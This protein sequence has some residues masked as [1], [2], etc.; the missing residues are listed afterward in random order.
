MINPLLLVVVGLVIGLCVGLTGVGGGALMTPILVLLGID[1]LTAVSSDLVVS[2]VMKPIGSSVHMRRGTVDRKIVVWLA[3]GSVPTAFLGAI[4]LEMFG[5]GTA[6]KQTVKYLLGAALLLAL[7]GML[8]RQEIAGRRLKHDHVESNEL[9]DAQQQQ[10]Q[11]AE[12]DGSLKLSVTNSRRGATIALGAVGGLIV[13]LTSV[14]SG[15][16][17]IVGLMWLFPRL[18][19]RS[20]VGTDL[21]QAIPLVGSAAIGHAL[22][23]RVDFGLALPLLIGAVPAVYLGARLSSKGQFSVIL[24]PILMVLIGLSALQLVGVPPIRS[25]AIVCVVTVFVGGAFWRRDRKQLGG[26]GREAFFDEPDS[27][28]TLAS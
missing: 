16:L 14:G 21:V 18:E 10:S 12:I 28:R 15:S 17:I 7:L 9:Q 8:L 6:I 1:P 19:Q 20:L 26:Q 13:G 5:K 3:L 2:L 24:R 22:F 4:A 27:V 23:G 25:V 11:S